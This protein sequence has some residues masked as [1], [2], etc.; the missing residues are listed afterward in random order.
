MTTDGKESHLL[1]VHPFVFQ[2][3]LILI[4]IL[5]NQAYKLYKTK[6]SSSVLIQH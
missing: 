3:I 5:R 6:K 2:M 1:V 4:S